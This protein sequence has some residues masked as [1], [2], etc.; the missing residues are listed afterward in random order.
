MGSSL[1]RESIV[2]RP[3]PRAGMPGTGTGAGRPEKG[4]PAGPAR[5]APAPAPSDVNAARRLAG[6]ADRVTK[7]V[8]GAA[9]GPAAGR[10]RPV[11]IRTPLEAGRTSR[12]VRSATGSERRSTAL[13]THIFSRLEPFRSIGSRLDVVGRARLETCPDGQRRDER[14]ASGDKSPPDPAGRPRLTQ[15]PGSLGR[16]CSVRERPRHPPL[17][18]GMRAAGHPAPLHAGPTRGAI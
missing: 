7:R 11:G 10:T 8:P 3:F 12:R 4:V 14:G 13:A 5:I 18:G 2:F 6:A 1:H 16:M 17:P 9:L 15:Q